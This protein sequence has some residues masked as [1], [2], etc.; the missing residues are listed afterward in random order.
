MP[1]VR[2][3]VAGGASAERVGSLQNDVDAPTP[4]QEETAS[5]HSGSIAH[6]GNCECTPS[7]AIGAASPPRNCRGAPLSGSCEVTA[8]STLAGSFAN[9]GNFTTS[10]NS[11]GPEFPARS[12]ACGDALARTASRLPQLEPRA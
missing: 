9:V 1:H 10:G 3:V 11:C 8:C 4:P 5:L 2:G 6:I 7:T 12:R